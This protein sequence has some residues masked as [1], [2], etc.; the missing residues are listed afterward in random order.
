MTLPLTG[1]TVLAVEQYGAGPF[2][3][4]LLGDLTDS[5]EQPL[6]SPDRDVG[7]A[8]RPLLAQMEGPHEQV[9]AG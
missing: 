8:R 3:T 6:E 2:G 5:L 7:I 4:M 9:V 1:V